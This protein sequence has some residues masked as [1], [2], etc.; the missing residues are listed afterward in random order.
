MLRAHLEKAT[1]PVKAARWLDDSEIA[2]GIAGMPPAEVVEWARAIC[3]AEYLDPDGDT[4]FEDL[5]DEVVQASE[6]WRT[7]LLEW[8]TEHEDSDHR[9]YLLAAAVLDGAPVE[10]IYAAAETLAEALGETPAPRPGQQGL[11]VIALTHAIKADLSDEDT[12]CFRGPATSR[13]SST[14]SG[15]TALIS[16]SSS[17]AGRPTRPATRTCL[18]T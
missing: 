16:F 18:T 2:E 4:P 3:E 8:H 10:T 5:V 9:N 15:P 17:P 7:R 1:P 6:D 13:P 11:G 14:T 12:V